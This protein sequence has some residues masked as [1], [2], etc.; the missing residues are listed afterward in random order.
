MTVLMSLGA[1]ALILAIG[2][3]I[4]AGLGFYLFILLHRHTR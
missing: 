1:V 3:V 4:G 2:V